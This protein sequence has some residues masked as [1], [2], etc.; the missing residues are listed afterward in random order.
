[1]VLF[2]MGFFFFFFTD[3]KFYRF[4]KF[5]NTKARIVYSQQ[6]IGY[7]IIPSSTSTPRPLLWVKKKKFFFLEILHSNKKELKSFKK[8]KKHQ[9]K[10]KESW[11][12]TSYTIQQEVTYNTHRDPL[13][14]SF[15]FFSLSHFTFLFSQPF[16]RFLQWSFL[17]H[18]IVQI[19]RW[20]THLNPYIS[21][22]FLAVLCDFSETVKTLKLFWVSWLLLSYA[23]SLSGLLQKSLCTQYYYYAIQGL[24]RT[25][26]YFHT[27]F[28]FFF[29]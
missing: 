23:N 13:S 27:I 4:W 25:I 18:W 7:N 28:F 8:K 3:W 11:T 14:F 15:S 1:M 20:N 29:L 21:C 22:S 12:F 24:K 6:D 2:F 10:V 17:F 5:T 16:M 26:I 19:P 9:I